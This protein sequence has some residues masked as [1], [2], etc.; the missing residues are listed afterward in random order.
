MKVAED[1]ARYGKKRLT[2]DAFMEQYGHIDD[3]NKY[4]LQDGEVVVSPQPGWKHGELHVILSGL[5]YLYSAEHTEYRMFDS[6]GVEFSTDTL[7]GPDLSVVKTT[8]PVRFEQS[9][10]VG[11]PSLVVEIVSPEKPS[12]DLM[13]KRTLYVKK[14]VPE[15]WFIEHKTETALFLLKRRSGE[16]SE[17]SMSSGIFESKVLKG[18]KL[19]VAALFAL[20]KKRLRKVLES[21]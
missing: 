20:D 10:M 9:I 18:F 14:G 1:R 11:V 13:K 15:I 7:R 3:G 2:V 4:E 8:D 5:L 16:Y 19:D 12:L 6:S 21:K 17:L